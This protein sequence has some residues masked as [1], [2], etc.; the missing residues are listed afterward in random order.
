MTR[1][2][3]AYQV[4]VTRIGKR[5]S[6]RAMDTGDAHEKFWAEC[7]EPAEWFEADKECMIAVYLDSKLN[8]ISWS[9]V[10]MGTCNMTL[11]QPLEVF[12]AALIEG[13]SGISLF[14]NHPSGDC[15]P[16]RM[17]YSITGVIVEA[18]RVLKMRFVDHLVMGDIDYFSFNKACF[19][20]TPMREKM[21]RTC[22]SSRRLYWMSDE[23]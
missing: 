20:Q 3:H 9:L 17:D 2:K 22:I 8:L 11:V 5:S 18:S 12:R 23:E 19:P 6:R 16:S 4:K 7:I 13:A 14:H 1:R 10:S 21:A 15:L